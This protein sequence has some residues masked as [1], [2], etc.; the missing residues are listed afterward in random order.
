MTF[1][2]DDRKAVLEA[3]ADEV[4]AKH[5]GR[6]YS[7]TVIMACEVCLRVNARKPSA[8]PPHYTMPTQPIAAEAEPPRRYWWQDND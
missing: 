5:E 4:R 6:P 7:E 1:T 2:D 3:L 8:E